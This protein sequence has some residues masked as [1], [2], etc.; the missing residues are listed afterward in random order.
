MKKVHGCWAKIE[1]PLVQWRKTG[2]FSMNGPSTIINLTPE[3]RSELEE[4]IRQTKE[5]KVADRVRVILYKAEGHSHKFIAN[6]LQM[7]RNQV[8][9]LLQ[10][11]N[12]GGLPALLQPNQAG[13]ST[14]KLTIEQQQA[15]KVELKTKIYATAFQVMAWVEKQWGIVYELSGMHKLLKR[16]GFSYKKNRLVPSQADPELQRQ[17][18]QWLAGLHQHMKPEDRLYFGDAVHFK[19]NA[20]AGFAWSEVALPHQ[21]PAN[22]GRQRYNVLGAYCIQTHD[23][24]FILT[25]D[26]IN[27]EKLV[28]FLGLLRAKHPNQGQIY[29]I[30]DNARYHHAQTVQ[31]AARQQRIRLEYLPP[32]SPNLNPIERLWKFVRKKFFKD[33]YRDTFAKFCAQLQNFFANLDQY[34]DELTTLLTENF[35]LLPGGWQPPVCA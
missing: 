12:Q 22:S 2:G 18:V 6:L 20:E 33:R 31:A 21:I 13:G 9:D 14:A 28:E 10:R 34:R 3:R 17:F 32:Y 8:T 11:F 25:P 30:L 5:R 4:Q 1:P 16:L 24:L 35:E 29:L 15:L 7:G 27:Q 26:N 23:H 19:H